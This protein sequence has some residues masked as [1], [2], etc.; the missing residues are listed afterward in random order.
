MKS[1][2][3]PIVLF[4]SVLIP[5][6]TSHTE[7]NTSAFA[8]STPQPTVT[9][10]PPVNQAA[11]ATATPADEKGLSADFA[12]TAGVTDEKNTIDGAA[13][14]S[15]VRTGQQENFDRIVFEFAGEELPSYHVEYLDKPVRSCG[16]GDVVPLKG[17]AW[18]E[19]RFTPANAHNE[20]GEPTVKTREMTPNHKV[21]K[22]LKATCDFEAEVEWVAGVA[23]PNKYRV[24][25][26]KSPTRLVVDI[27][28]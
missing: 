23:S 15:A 7:S 9:Q 10:T 19:I 20:H 17:D 1:P 3:L 13:L 14:L 22:E 2:I 16:S 18:L 11:A 12:G 27:K 6:C 5:G 24:L 4:V 26:L 21:V 25:E 8:P 28:H